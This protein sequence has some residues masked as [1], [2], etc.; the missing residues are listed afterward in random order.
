MHSTDYT[1][2]FIETAADCPVQQGTVPPDKEPKTIARRQF[3][4]IS[5]NP[6]RYTSDEIIFAVHAE[7][8]GI[9]KKHLGKAKLDF[10]AKGQACLRSSPLAK[11]YGWG[12]HFDEQSRVA[13]YGCESEQYRTFT[14]DDS[15]KHLKAMKSKR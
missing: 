11:Q 8:N 3:E 5:G 1:N 10:F 14:A 15:V 12:F 13:M 9:E 2:T 6:Y 7:R 4:L